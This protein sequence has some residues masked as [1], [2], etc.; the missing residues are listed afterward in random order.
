MTNKLHICTYV[1]AI[2]KSVRTLFSKST[3][4]CLFSLPFVGN[5]KCPA[6]IEP[7]YT[8][9]LFSP[10]YFY[11]IVLPPAF[12]AGDPFEQSKEGEKCSYRIIIV[13][14]KEKNKTLGAFGQQ[15]SHNQSLTLF[16]CLQATQLSLT[17][18]QEQSDFCPPEERNT[19]CVLSYVE[20]KKRKKNR[21][22]HPVL[23]FCNTFDPNAML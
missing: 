22:R 8:P 6:H 3:Y 7:V 18:S 17:G 14:K 20:G 1:A 9:V 12:S 16:F 10:Q 4:I 5:I 2:W 11:S 13:Q 15:R 19:P 21:K 23:S